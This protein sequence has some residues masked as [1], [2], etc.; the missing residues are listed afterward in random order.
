VLTTLWATLVTILLAAPPPADAGRLVVQ[1]DPS[2]ARVRIDDHAAGTA[3]L[4]RLLRRGPHTVEVALDGFESVEER[5]EI[6]EGEV[7][8]LVLTL[9]PEA[10]VHPQRRWGRICFFSGLG[11][12]AIGGAALAVAM[13]AADDYNQNGISGDKSRATTWTGVMYLGFG[14][15]AALLITG[16]ALWLSAPPDPEAPASAPLPAAVPT[17]DGRGLI[18]TLGGRW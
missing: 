1:T 3:P 8:E 2:G 10:P 11:A 17:P 5:I 4:S 12:T 6:A 13:G 9:I 15:G 18:L 14:A 16:A 7:C